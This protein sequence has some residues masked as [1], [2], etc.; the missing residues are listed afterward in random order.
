M[1]V[2]AL[3]DYRVTRWGDGTH[4][5]APP[6]DLKMKT[7]TPPPRVRAARG[8]DDRQ[9]MDVDA[10]Q[11]EQKTGKSKGFVLD[12][13]TESRVRTLE[14]KMDSALGDISESGNLS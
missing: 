4:W 10:E 5:S 9:H 1:D 7:K 3:M 2:A 12:E 8:E 11:A 6:V 13:N 14:Y